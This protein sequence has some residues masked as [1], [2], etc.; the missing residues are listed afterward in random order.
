[1]IYKKLHKKVATKLR[2]NVA[3]LISCHTKVSSTH[4]GIIL[5]FSLEYTL[6]IVP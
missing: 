2:E 6:R 3:Q 1:V 4:A 5:I